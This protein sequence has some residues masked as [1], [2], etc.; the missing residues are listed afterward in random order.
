M[1][2]LSALKD[3]EFDP[4]PKKQYN[5]SFSYKRIYKNKLTASDRIIVRKNKTCTCAMADIEINNRY[6]GRRSGFQPNI[7]TFISCIIFRV[8]K[9]TGEYQSFLVHKNPFS[10][11]GGR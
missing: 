4:S 1:F 3:K 11:S 2:F 9:P 6:L 5:V 8:L 10:L 7:Y